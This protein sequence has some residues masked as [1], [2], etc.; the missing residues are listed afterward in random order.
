MDADGAEVT[1]LFTPPS[2]VWLML[3][4]KF[5][6]DP[7]EPLP[8]PGPPS[9]L[10]GEEAGAEGPDTGNNFDGCTESTSGRVGD[11]VGEAENVGNEKL[12]PASADLRR[13][14]HASPGRIPRSSAAFRKPLMNA[15]S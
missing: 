6:G 2:P 3:Y 14:S 8:A 12:P 1:E 13:M 10:V 7:N 5:F 4:P 11:C 15:C 9:E